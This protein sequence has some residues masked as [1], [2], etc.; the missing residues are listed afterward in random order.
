VAE[1]QG[2]FDKSLIEVGFPGVPDEVQETSPTT[3]EL[4]RKEEAAFFART[5]FEY[6]T[7]VRVFNCGDTKEAQELADLTTKFMNVKPPK[8]VGD[9]PGYLRL[10]EESTFTKD[11]FYLVALRWAEFRKVKVPE[12]VPED[13]DAKDEFKSDQSASL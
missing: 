6:T 11:G 13:K 12:P 3:N 10:K 8:K 4:T 9:P 1:G 2:S 5:E 7:F